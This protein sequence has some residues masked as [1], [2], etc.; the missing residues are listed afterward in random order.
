MIAIESNR[1]MAKVESTL[2]MRAVVSN[3]NWVAL[4]AL[5]VMHQTGR[6]FLHQIR[7]NMVEP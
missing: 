6:Q 2:R 7:R 3:H 4:D 1:F 5:L